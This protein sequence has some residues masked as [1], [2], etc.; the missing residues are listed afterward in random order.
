MQEVSAVFQ[1]IYA[2]PHVTENRVS[3]GGVGVLTDKAGNAI[4]FGGVRILVDTGGPDTAYNEDVIVSIRTSRKLFSDAPM[5]G[6]AAAGEIELEMIKPAAEI[7]RRARIVPY[8][9]ISDG[10]RV[11]EWIQKGAYYVDARDEVP[12]SNGVWSCLT[13]HGFDGML[14]AESD[15]PSGSGLDWPAADIDIVQEI[16]DYL[17]LGVDDRVYR[18]MVEGYPVQ[19]PAGYSCRE[20]LGYI[21]AMYAGNWVMNDHGELML[22]PLAGIP[23]ETRY[24]I[25]GKDD[26]SAITFGGDRIL[27]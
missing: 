27:V 2:G 6:A 23:P 18:I 7:P 8:L 4:T 10:T 19:Y 25:V 24:L 3:I 5:V 17:G 9:R 20:I 26:G 1:E 22:I 14:Y 15:Y 13:L 21:G 11:S 12:S 16:A